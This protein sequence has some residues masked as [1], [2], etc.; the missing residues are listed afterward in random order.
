MINSLRKSKSELILNGDLNSELLAVG[1]T[2][3]A[4]WSRSGDTVCGVTSVCSHTDPIT[5]SQPVLPR[6][7]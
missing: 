6:L 1:L 3:H 2:D 7:V 4:F 5:H